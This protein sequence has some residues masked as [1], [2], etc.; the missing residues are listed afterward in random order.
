[1]R[2]LVI[3]FSL[4]FLLPCQSF[5]QQALVDIPIFA[6]HRF[7]D[8]RYPSTNID[9]QVFEEQLKFLSENN[10]EVLTFGQA[11]QVGKQGKTLMAKAV[12]LTIDDGYLSFY[13]YGWP[14]LK[15][16]GYNATIFIQCQTAGGGDFMSW[17]QIKEI[18]EAGIEIGNH[19]AAHTYFLN[20]PGQ[21]RKQAF[22]EDLIQ[23]G[24]DFKSHLGFS[25]KYYAYPYGE[26]T[27]DMQAVLKAEG[28]EAA[29]A[30]KSGVFSGAVDFFAIP[31]FPMGGPFGTLEG[32]KNKTTMKTLRVLETEPQS[33]F[34]D[35]NPPSL[36]ITIAPGQVNIKNAQFFVQGNKMEIDETN[37]DSS[38]P[39]VV[40]KS[41]KKLTARRTLY[42]L[43]APSSDGKSWC[44]Y[45]YLW[46]RP[47]V[48]E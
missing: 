27:A 20:L 41:S 46:V 39:F 11:V 40:L 30:Q 4:I 17:D 13:T 31:R 45:S 6:Y 29:A 24:E 12:V 47:G 32:F 14:L 48:E 2:T 10:F 26:Y 18:Q 33:P 1:M 22:T 36:K 43:T 37:N 19:S 23:A 15:K 35:E 9:T 21:E 5:A 25:P 34:V 42:T 3:I 44:W 8:H 16:Y 7:G 28:I 38:P